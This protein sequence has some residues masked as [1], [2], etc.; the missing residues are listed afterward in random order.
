G[1]HT[2]EVPSAL[3][4]MLIASLI[5]A[6]EGITALRAALANRLQRSINLC[7]GS[8]L[9]TVA[10]TVPVVLMIGLATGQ[11]ITLGLDDENIIMLVLTLMVSMLTFSGAR[12]N[13][14]QGAVH[15]L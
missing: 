12:T 2:L 3:G 10:L 15:L 5:L 6:P 9:S 11:S 4:G 14:L 7:L 8:A 1:I 13:V